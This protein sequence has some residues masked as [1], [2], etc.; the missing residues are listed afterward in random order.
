VLDDMG[1]P[2]KRKKPFLEAMLQSKL[3]QNRAIDCG[4]NRQY[5]QRVTGEPAPRDRSEKWLQLRSADSCVRRFCARRATQLLCEHWTT[6]RR[7]RRGV[8]EDMRVF[9]VLCVLSVPASRP[10]CTSL[11]G[12]SPKR[13][14]F[15]ATV[16]I[17]I[18]KLFS[19]SRIA[20][21][22]ARAIV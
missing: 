8:A 13:A 16:M 19:T 5:A 18:A 12:D 9:C 10:R 17:A 1:T 2:R 11:R 4:G 7:A 3:Q 21:P 6:V 20:I 22:F 14:T 15:R